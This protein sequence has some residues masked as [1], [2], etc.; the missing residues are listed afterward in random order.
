MAPGTP[1]LDRRPKHVWLALVLLLLLGSLF[2]LGLLGRPGSVHDRQYRSFLIARAMYLDASDEAADWRKHVARA[3]SERQESLEPPLVEYLV[4]SVYRVIGR[5]SWKVARIVTSGF[6]LLGGVLLFM[7]ARRLH[8]AAAALFSTAYYLLVPTGVVLSLSFLPESLMIAM[9][10]ASLLAIVRFVERP[11]VPRWLLAGAVSA[12]AILIK[13][14]VVPALLGAFAALM[15]SESRTWRALFSW[16]VLG[17]GLVS[18]L[19]SALYYGRG[20]FVEDYLRWKVDASFLPHLLVARHFWEGWFGAGIAAVGVAPLALAVLG[21]ALLGDARRRALIAGLGAGYLAFC[22]LFNYFTSFVVYYHVQLIPIVALALGPLLA[23]LTRRL[24][25]SA[26]A[27][28]AWAALAVAAALLAVASYLE[29]RDRQVAPRFEGRQLAAEIGELVEHSE[30]VAHV[31]YVYGLPLEYHGELA[32]E[33]WP[34]ARKGWPLA[35]GDEVPSSVEQRLSRLG[36][37]PEYFV[38][39]NFREF[40]GH[41]DDLRSWLDEHGTVVAQTD[42]YLIYALPRGDGSADGRADS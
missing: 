30:R 37:E 41:H 36:F 18:V 26:G 21:G 20:I 17:F 3:S 28:P 8:S 32:G 5:E 34:R 33:S 11:T 16:Q 14:L 31:A 38:I 13:P 15:W 22:L 2:R 10:L 24:F 1:F 25:R 19:P 9:M 29:A 7:L 12:A 42:S 39:T 40:L 23:G 35:S 6:W 27:R 4:S